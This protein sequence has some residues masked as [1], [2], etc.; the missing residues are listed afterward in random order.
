MTPIPKFGLYLFSE[1]IM[2]TAYTG[3]NY[4][5]IT[6]YTQNLIEDKFSF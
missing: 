3:L 2:I 6:A 4:I 1:I 5:L